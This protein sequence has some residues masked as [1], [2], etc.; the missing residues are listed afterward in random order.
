MADSVPVRD[1]GLTTPYIRFTYSKERS[2]L[3]L[4]LEQNKKIGCFV[5]NSSMDRAANGLEGKNVSL[6]PA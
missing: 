2:G 1:L 3:K 4:S 6:N 5:Q